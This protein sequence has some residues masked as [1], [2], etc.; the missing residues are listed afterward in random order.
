MLAPFDGFSSRASRSSK[1]SGL[2]KMPN[3]AIAHA[4]N[5]ARIYIVER[6][7]HG[8]QEVIAHGS[9]VRLKTD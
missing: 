2:V 9:S 1:P 4:S 3:G 8:G 5:V 7:C 6:R